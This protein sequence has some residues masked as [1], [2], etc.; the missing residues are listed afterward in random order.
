[1][2]E[3]EVT[4]LNYTSSGKNYSHSGKI[5]VVMQETVDGDWL[6]KNAFFDHTEGYLTGQENFNINEK[7]R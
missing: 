3:C 4:N 2:G 6:L 7:I 1:M 5:N